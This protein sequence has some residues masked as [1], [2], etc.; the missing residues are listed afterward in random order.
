[1]RCTLRRE[2]DI[3]VSS[4]TGTR[5]R[6]VTVV[7]L[8]TVPFSLAY[9]AGHL[10]SQVQAGYD[11]HVISSPGPELELFA[12]SSGAH[13]HA[14][15]I[16]RPIDPVND[17]RALSRVLLALRRLHPDVVHAH[18]PKAGLL[19]MIAARALGV[20][21]RIYHCHGLPFETARGAKRL[22]LYAAE[23]TACSLAS[24]VLTVSASLREVIIRAR[25]CAPSRIDVPVKGSIG[26]VDAATRFRPAAPAARR[27]ARCALGVPEDA[28]VIGFV[29][30]L[31]RDKGIVE[32]VQAWRA[33]SARMAD[34]H[35]VVVGPFEENDAVPEA[36]VAAMRSD[37]RIHLVGVD[38]DT[39]RLFAAMDVVA[40]PSYREGFPVVA[41][42]AAAM[43][44]PIVA[45]RATGCVDAVEDGVTGT[46]V[47]V[48]SPGELESALARY[49]DDPALRQ[50]HGEAARARAVREYDPERLHAA[51][52]ALYDAALGRTAE[53]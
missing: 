45:S 1:M 17:V 6:G 46:L 4:S 7:H 34:L 38:W 8:T 52:Q 26:G 35:W 13:V 53:A 33:L 11:V 36:V 18:T 10:R 29:G 48:G 15:E 27:A 3:A 39:P 30:R 40:L 22:V 50:A 24:R 16:P 32:L 25:L 42:E 2:A 23:R 37:P 31:V 21:V 19:G 43:G 49:L 12:A 14:V 20:P 9:L 47:T 5:G 41:L 44:L 28:R 51:V